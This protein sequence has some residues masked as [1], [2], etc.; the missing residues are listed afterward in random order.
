MPLVIKT[1]IKVPH[2]KVQ[3]NSSSRS[4]WYQGGHGTEDLQTFDIVSTYNHVK[5]TKFNI[6]AVGETDSEPS[7]LF[8]HFGPS[9]NAL[10]FELISDGIIGGPVGATSGTPIDIS[11]NASGYDFSNNS[12][13]TVIV[14]AGMDG[15]YNDISC[16]GDGTNW[17]ITI[18]S[19]QAI[20]L[21]TGK[22]IDVE[23]LPLEGGVVHFKSP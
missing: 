15:I 2:L 12:V 11:T 20:N 4:G 16:A 5:F 6:T 17:K 9:T 1:N 22:T 18:N 8:C 7:Y 10:N 21:E 3:L 13:K 19:L 23:G 14:R